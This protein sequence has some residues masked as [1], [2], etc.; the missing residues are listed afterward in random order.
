MKVLSIIGIYLSYTIIIATQIP[1]THLI[2]TTTPAGSSCFQTT[3][4]SSNRPFLLSHHNTMMFISCPPQSFTIKVWVK[5]LKPDKDTQGPK[6]S[7]QW[8]HDHCSASESKQW[9]RTTLKDRA[10]RANRTTAFQVITTTSSQLYTDDFQLILRENN[11]LFP[12]TDKTRTTTNVEH[13][14]FSSQGLVQEVHPCDDGK[15]KNHEAAVKLTEP[16]ELRLKGPLE[17][18]SPPQQ[19]RVK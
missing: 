17:I 3:Y 14:Q 11:S 18:I 16:R 5:K 2:L 8:W 13:L 12:K 1:H 15:L 6:A 9:H 10:Q 19:S 7:C 4:A